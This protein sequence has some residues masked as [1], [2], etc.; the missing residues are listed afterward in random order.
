M[1]Q[2][3]RA[4]EPFPGDQGLPQDWKGSTDLNGE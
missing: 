1:R 4:S 2:N 3:R